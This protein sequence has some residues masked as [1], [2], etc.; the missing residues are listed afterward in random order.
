MFIFVF[1]LEDRSSKLEKSFHEIVLHLCSEISVLCLDFN[2][3][4][5]L[6]SCANNYS[7]VYS[8]TM[9]NQSG[10]PKLSLG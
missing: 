10:M 9:V 6:F 4:L 5:P 7:L 8:H 2:S 1:L 3:L